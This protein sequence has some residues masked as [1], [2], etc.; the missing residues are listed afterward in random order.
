MAVFSI[1]CSLLLM[2]TV[3]ITFWTCIFGVSFC[4]TLAMCIHFAPGK[5]STCTFALTTYGILER[6]CDWHLPGHHFSRGIRMPNYIWAWTLILIISVIVGLIC[7]T[8]SCT[9]I[10]PVLRVRVGNRFSGL[11]EGSV[12]VLMKESFLCRD[13]FITSHSPISPF[14]RSHWTRRSRRD[15]V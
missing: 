5:L 12:W 6:F 2:P 8:G 10:S 1:F 9:V 11:E 13:P 15:A 3:S 7:S 4:R 14:L